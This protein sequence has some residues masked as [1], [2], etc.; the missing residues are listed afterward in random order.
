M[1]SDPPFNRKSHPGV[2]AGRFCF[3]DGMAAARIT[4]VMSTS[5]YKGE[6]DQR[7]HE[8]IEISKLL[9]RYGS[10][11]ELADWGYDQALIDAVIA[12]REATQSG[13][14]SR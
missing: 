1:E 9:L 2:Y 13:R 14:G 7:M 5:S 6:W 12:Y 10:R 3:S 4:G 8:A 11:S